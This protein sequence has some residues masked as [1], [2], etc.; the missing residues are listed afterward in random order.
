MCRP[1]IAGKTEFFTDTGLRVFKM[2][3]DPVKTVG[4]IEELDMR[5]VAGAGPSNLRRDILV[6]VAVRLLSQSHREPARRSRPLS[7]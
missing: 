4:I 6:G 2:T 1:S 5:R 3:R 7:L